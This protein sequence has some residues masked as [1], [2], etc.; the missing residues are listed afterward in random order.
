MVEAER[1]E[2]IRLWGGGVGVRVDDNMRLKLTID[3]EK[4]ATTSTEP[5]AYERT[6]VFASLEYLP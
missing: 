6:R 1:L 3:R 2:T 4:R 5:R